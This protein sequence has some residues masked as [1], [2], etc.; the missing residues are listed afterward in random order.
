MM[1]IKTGDTPKYIATSLKFNVTHP[2]NCSNIREMDQNES[3]SLKIN[4]FVK[5]EYHSLPNLITMEKNGT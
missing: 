3:K 2:L 5:F 4:T 1:E